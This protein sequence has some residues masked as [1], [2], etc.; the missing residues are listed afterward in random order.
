MLTEKMQLTLIPGK[1]EPDFQQTELYN[2]VYQTWKNIWRDEF[3]KVG[4]PN[5]WH[6]DSFLRQDCIPIITSEKGE[7][8][9]F[10]LL[11]FYSLNHLSTS[12]CSYLSIF[13][14]EA[15][16]ELKKKSV[17]EFMTLEYLTVSPEWRKGRAG[18]PMAALI[19]AIA[20]KV[21]EE[22]QADAALGVARIDYGVNTLCMSMGAKSIYAEARRGNL[23]CELISFFKGEVK[24]H[25]NPLVV[26]AVH[27]LWKDR[28]DLTKPLIRN[29]D[30]Q[31]FA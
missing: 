14:K 8:L 4:S 28:L 5:A 31:K 16:D 7:P 15:I 22:R 13:P 3:T 19:M 29:S 20:L 18:L 23:I 21:F 11:S 10:F 1:C 25:K 30:F 17:E 6:G 27:S 2:E 12:D 24:P 26:E 9:A